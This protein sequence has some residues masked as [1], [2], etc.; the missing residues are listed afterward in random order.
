MKWGYLE[1]VEIETRPDGT[2]YKVA[3]YS[4]SE[5][6]EAGIREFEMDEKV[7]D[8][9]EFGGWDEDSWKYE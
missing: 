8:M 5:G 6:G 7:P 1:N 9:E 2:Q 3:F 4:D